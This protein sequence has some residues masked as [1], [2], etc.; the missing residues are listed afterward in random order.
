LSIQ[1]GR[2]QSLGA[3]QVLDHFVC[4]G[5]QL[6]V[7]DLLEQMYK[8]VGVGDGIGAC[9]RKPAP[10]LVEILGAAG[11]AEG[12]VTTHCPESS[13]VSFGRASAQ[14]GERVRQDL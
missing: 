4:N 5:A 9:S 6:F 13:K 7:I 2:W 3:Y 11:E 14:I 12:R 8:S 10:V 1:Q